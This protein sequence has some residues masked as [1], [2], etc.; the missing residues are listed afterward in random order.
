MKE[1]LNTLF[2]KL[3]KNIRARFKAKRFDI[4]KEKIVKSGNEGYFIYEDTIYYGNRWSVFFES[5][6]TKWYAIKI[7]EAG[8][9]LPL[10]ENVN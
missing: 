5:D 4:Y 2:A 7:I 10:E 9:T 8:R 6:Q 3:P 1:L